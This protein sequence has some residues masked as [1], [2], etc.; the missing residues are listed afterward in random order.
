MNVFQYDPKVGSTHAY[1]VDAIVGYDEFK[2]DQA[3]ILLF[4][5]AIQ[6]K[7]LD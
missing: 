2:M 6:M 3:F 4:Q 7:G 1:I 5:Q